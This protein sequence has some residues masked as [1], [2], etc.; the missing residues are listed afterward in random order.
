MDGLD[1]GDLDDAV[2]IGASM[3][4]PEVFGSLFDR[5]GP[6][7]HRYLQR[8][9]GPDVADDLLAETFMAAFRR[10]GSYDGTR[11]NARPW[12]YGI[13]AKVISEHR[14]AELRR[15]RLQAAIR[16]EPGVPGHDEDVSNRVSAQ[17]VR[18]QLVEA[19]AGLSGRDREVLLLIAWEELSYAEVATALDIPVGTV[20]SRLYR[21]RQQLRAA[22]GGAN[23]LR[24]AESTLEEM[25]T[26]A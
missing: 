24:L 4:D 2:V 26:D 19:I 6:Y 15:L 18:R 3:T 22:L 13:A 11:P 21:T 17:A 16:P 23:P 10:R 9:L 7:I 1:Q 12:L 25:L 14:R 5:H 20:R 8:R